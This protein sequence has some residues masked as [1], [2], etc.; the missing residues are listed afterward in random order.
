MHTGIVRAF[1]YDRDRA[2]PRATAKFLSP[3]QKLLV[4]FRRQVIQ[5]IQRLLVPLMLAVLD[6]VNHILIQLLPTD[7][8]L[9]HEVEGNPLAQ[10]AVSFRILDSDTAGGSNH[11]KAE[12]T[13]D[14]D[15]DGEFVNTSSQIRE[16]VFC[17]N[18]GAPVELAS[19]FDRVITTDSS[20]EH[21]GES[22]EDGIESELSIAT[23]DAI[24]AV[25]GESTNEGEDTE[26]SFEMI[27]IDELNGFKV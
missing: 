18:P 6:I 17:L 9:I 23:I 19:G 12:V 8:E 13:R 22:A 20:N 10:K 2:D 27:D 1:L 3:L 25:S 4:S 24:E 26:F 5:G 21:G 15:F 16:Q 7:T 11:D 14:C